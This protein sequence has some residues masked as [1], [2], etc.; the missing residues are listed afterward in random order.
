MAQRQVSATI[1]IGAFSLQSLAFSPDGALLVST[2]QNNKVCLWSVAE[3]RQLLEL[4]DH[5]NW[6]H[7]A[8][9]SPD[10]TLIASGGDDKPLRLWRVAWE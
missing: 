6:V 10:G 1:T 3:R 7:S 2:G 8:V 5:G 4:K 9:F